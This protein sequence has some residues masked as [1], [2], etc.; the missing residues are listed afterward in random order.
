[1]P[2]ELQAAQPSPEEIIVVADGESDGSWRLAEELG[3]QVLRIPTAGGSCPGAQ[4]VE[5]R[6]R[7]GVS[8]SLWT[9]T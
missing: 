8:S 5:H 7:R 9:L 3:L 2:G 6:E 4:S 1:M